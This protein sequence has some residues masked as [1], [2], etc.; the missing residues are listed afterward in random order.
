MTSDEKAQIVLQAARTV[1]M[2][3]GFSAATTDMIQREASVSKSTVYEHYPTKEALFAAVIETECEKSMTNVRNVASRATGGLRETL[4]ALA[5]AYI[6]LVLSPG[7]LALFRVA[8]GEAP[9]FPD[10]ARTFYQAGPRVIRTMVAEHL[11]SAAASGEIDVSELGVDA[12][13]GVFVSLVRGDAYI[14]YLTHPDA[15]PTAAQMDEWV[16]IAVTTFLR[17]YGSK[18]LAPRRAKGDNA[19][20][21]V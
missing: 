9:R 20:N 11:A 16:E 15:T 6:D 12:A 10:L 2:A 14:L 7:G 13:A 4:S 8:V 21:R 3:H 1:F 17:A 5:R 19:R 18:R